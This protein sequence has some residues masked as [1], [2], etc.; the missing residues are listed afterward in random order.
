MELRPSSSRQLIFSGV[1]SFL[2]RSRSPFF[3]AS[4]R[5]ESPLS[6]SA[7][8]PSCSLT[9][10]SAVRL[11]LLR[12]LTSAPCCSR[13]RDLLICSIHFSRRYVLSR[14]IY[15]VRMI[16]CW[17]MCER[18][19][20]RVIMQ[21][22]AHFEQEFADLVLALGGCL[23]EWGELPQIHYVHASHV[24]Y[25]LFCHLIVAV[26]TGVVERNQPSGGTTTDNVTDRNTERQTNRQTDKQTNR[27]TDRHRQTDTDRQTDRQTDKR[28]NEQKHRQK[29]YSS[30]SSTSKLDKSVTYAPEK[31][32]NIRIELNI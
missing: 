10:S 11:S 26:G 22:S 25:Q 9:R 4:S 6:R 2:I 8:S 3:A 1:S 12:R 20:I 17:C 32:V 18:E 30:I 13:E 28:T 23:M 14:I 15:N 21:V 5:A 27:Q 7:R 29:E 19:K 16:L 24:L 31:K